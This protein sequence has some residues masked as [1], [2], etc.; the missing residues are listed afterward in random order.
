MTHSHRFHGVYPVLYAFFDRTGR[1]DQ[2]AM[3][4]QVEH[5]IAAGALGLMVLGLVTE[6]NKM[7]VRERLQVV[8]L[9][10]GLNQGRLPY[11]VT[12]GEPSIEGQIAFA[13]EARAAGADWVILQPPPARGGGEAELIRF[14]GSVADALDFPVA[15][16]HNPFN[17]D[18]W[19]SVEGMIALHRQHPNICVLKGEGTAIETERLIAGTDG[20]LDVFGG[21]GGI[22]FL[23]VLRAGAAGLIPAPDCL[24]IQVK[25]YELFR[26][27]TPEALAEAERLHKE[28]L[29]L[30]VFMIRSIPALLCYGKR[31]MAKRLRLDEIFDRAP[32]ITP[33]AFGLAEMER[34]FGSLEALEQMEK[35]R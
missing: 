28:V 11:A 13:R 20:K 25:I 5:C 7:D 31:F 34:L 12:V 35:P 24:P 30:I 19:L 29:P 1:L 3:S 14:F 23:S 22:E 17:L 18:V 32:A 33:T 21:H 6:V 8:E 16:Q 2:D 27:G 9:V 26:Q 15:I 10:G 4:R